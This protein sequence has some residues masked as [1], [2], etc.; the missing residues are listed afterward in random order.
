MGND[1]RILLTITFIALTAL[2]IAK[3]KDNLAGTI[4]QASSVVT[5]LTYNMPNW[6]NIPY[7]ANILPGAT[8]SFLGAP[9]TI[10]TSTENPWW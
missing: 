5:S 7:T 1:E 8:S 6:N 9:T 4:G 2:I 3:F 10:D